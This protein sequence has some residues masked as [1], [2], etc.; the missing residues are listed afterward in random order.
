VVKTDDRA[1]L[2]RHRATMAAGKTALVHPGVRFLAWVVR[3][4]AVNSPMV[5]SSAETSP[6][7]S[8]RRAVASPVSVWLTSGVTGPTGSDRVQ[9]WVHCT[10]CTQLFE[11]LVFKRVFEMNFQNL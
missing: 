3:L 10:G 7:T 11:R 6:T 8:S 2:Q 1:A 9:L 4:V 5:T